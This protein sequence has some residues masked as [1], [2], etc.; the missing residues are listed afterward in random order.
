MRTILLIIIA[1]VFSALPAQ[2][3]SVYSIKHKDRVM[4]DYEIHIDFPN[5]DGLINK[6]LEQEVNGQIKSEIEETMEEVKRAG[7][8][9]VGIPVL[10]YGESSVIED[11]D[12]ISVILI[13]N[14][15]KG[16][17]YASSVRS[18]NFENKEGGVFMNLEDVAHLDKLNV[19]VERKLARDPET[20]K[21]QNFGGV[22]KDTAYY[23]ND[24]KLTL[25]FDKYEIASGVYGTP[26]ISIPYQLVKK[27][28]PQHKKSVPIPK[29]V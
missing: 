8:E 27:E 24:G 22:R 28:K 1:V 21:V 5:F 25:V 10:Y 11:K 19:E 29:T 20:F 14:I 6:N 26:E 18:I 17:H 13:S 7:E 2:A 3:E 23:I 15:T 16:D 4:E 9:S 12:L